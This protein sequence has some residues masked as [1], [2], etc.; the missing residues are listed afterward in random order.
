LLVPIILFLL[1]LPNK[2]PQVHAAPVHV[3]LTQEA[4]GFAG[5]IASAPASE[6]EALSWIAALY[7]VQGDARPIGFKELETLANSDD[8][9]RRQMNGKTVWVR[10]QFQPSPSN[11]HV[12]NLVRFRIS[13]CAADAVPLKVPMVTRQSL[14]S[15]GLKVSDWVKVTG[16]VDFRQQDGRNIAVLRVLDPKWIEKCDPD[17]SYIQ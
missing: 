7:L 16:V 11:D 12:F 9:S 8:E 15:S 2:G 10:G 4:A 13:C 1:G 6:G 17:P 5:M 3:D 14:A